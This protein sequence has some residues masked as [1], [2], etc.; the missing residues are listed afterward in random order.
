VLRRKLAVQSPDPLR[1]GRGS[2][3][4]WGAPC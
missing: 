2:C 3:V 1:A 4:V